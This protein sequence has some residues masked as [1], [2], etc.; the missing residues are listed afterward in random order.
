M[1]TLITHIVTL[2]VQYQNHCVQ[3]ILMNVYQHLEESFETS[4]LSVLPPNHCSKGEI[5]QDIQ[6]QLNEFGKS[7][8]NHRVWPLVRGKLKNVVLDLFVIFFDMLCI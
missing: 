8:T 1:T 2:D 7:K 5:V 4:I 6:V 3:L